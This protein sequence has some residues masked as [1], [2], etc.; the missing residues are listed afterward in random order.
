MLLNLVLLIVCLRYLQVQ[1]DP[2]HGIIAGRSLEISLSIISNIF[3]FSKHS[4]HRPPSSSQVTNETLTTSKSEPPSPSPV[5]NQ[6][7]RLIDDHDKR[8]Y[9]Q[10]E[11]Y[12]STEIGCPIKLLLSKQIQS[13]YKEKQKY[14]SPSSSFGTIVFVLLVRIPLR[15]V[16][17][18]FVQ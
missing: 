13:E 15:K 1:R 10:I 18:T 11:E 6:D 3:E 17:I 12:L 8:E 2:I 9:Q 5:H 16:C 7:I 14:C 4:N